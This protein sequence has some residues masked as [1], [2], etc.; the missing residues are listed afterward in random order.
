M[1][2]EKRMK[3]EDLV[4]KISLWKRDWESTVAS[5]YMVLGG[6]IKVDI[7][8]MTHDDGYFVAYP[9][10]KD[11]KQDKWFDQVVPVTDEGKLDKE[12]SKA[13]TA[14]VVKVYENLEDDAPF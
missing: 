7:R 12:V 4:T 13:I 1:A 3:P 6:I 5:G 8:L 11:T 9:S 2:K 14:M 10:R